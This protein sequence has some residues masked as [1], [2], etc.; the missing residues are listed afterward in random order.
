MARPLNVAIDL[1]G[2]LL[3]HKFPAWGEFKPG[4][5][6]AVKA[7]M[8]EG[9]FVSVFTVRCNDRLWGPAEA[10]RARHHIRAMLD[11]AGLEAV[12]IE[13]DN[14][15]LFDVLI[16]DRAIRFPSPGSDRAWPRIA[17]RVLGLK[18]HG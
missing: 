2:T 9:C 5:V 16:D 18:R 4:A 10:F 17:Q 1:D 7:L 13:Q 8:A 15:P 11:E 3:E 12:A 6:E 14:K